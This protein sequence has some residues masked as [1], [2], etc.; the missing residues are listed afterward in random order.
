[1]AAAQKL[2]E[3][4]RRLESSQDLLGSEVV[5][6]ERIN[7]IETVLSALAGG[8]TDPSKWSDDLRKAVAVAGSLPSLSDDAIS[9]LREARRPRLIPLA[10]AREHQ[11][12]FVDEGAKVANILSRR[13][14]ASETLVETYLKELETLTDIRE[15]VNNQTSWPSQSLLQLNKDL[16]PDEKRLLYELLGTYFDE[17]PRFQ[18]EERA[19]EYARLATFYDE[20]QARSKSAALMW[21]NSFDGIANTLA[22][23]HSTGIKPEELARLIQAL[24]V[25][26]IGVG[27][28]R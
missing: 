16:K 1:M 12:L 13:I 7:Q 15:K 22:T 6:E 26:A 17:V 9:T 25:T 14:A 20:T 19:L 2:R 8:E 3:T 4:I 27:A 28:N 21:Q 23:Y 11:R 24:G 18:S 10:I 5:A